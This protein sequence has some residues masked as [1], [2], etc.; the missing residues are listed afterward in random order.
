MSKRSHESVSLR[1]VVKD[2]PLLPFDLVTSIVAAAA[3]LIVLVA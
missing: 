1:D 2:D 3:F